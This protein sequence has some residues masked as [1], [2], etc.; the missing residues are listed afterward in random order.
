MQYMAIMLCSGSRSEQPHKR[1][2]YMGKTM[3][4]PPP[5]PE[6]VA[7][8]WGQR[9]KRLL[10][11]AAVAF[12]VSGLALI[13]IEYRSKL[14][15]T[16]NHMLRKTPAVVQVPS[17]YHAE[18]PQAKEMQGII[19]K[20]AESDHNHMLPIAPQ[21][22]E[23]L[24]QPQQQLQTPKLQPQPSV[25]AEQPIQQQQPQESIQIQ[26][27]RS[28]S[29]P[30]EIFYVVPSSVS[31]PFVHEPASIKP[32]KHGPFGFIKKLWPFHKKRSDKD[33]APAKADGKWHHFH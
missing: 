30:P 23:Q 24:R 19:R 27:E 15:N 20:L 29:A 8:V 32:K 33:P 9:R 6:P 3:G 18:S 26:K 14:R 4:C 2:V 25:Q 13:G 12:V 1:M 17:Q 16:F 22:P 28:A 7:D 10:K 21:L 31:D 11:V 5:P